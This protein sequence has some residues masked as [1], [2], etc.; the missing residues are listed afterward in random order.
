M[1]EQDFEVVVVWWRGGGRMVV[2]RERMKLVDVVECE[3]MMVH[4]T[5]V[6]DS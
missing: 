1:V 2:M 4:G 6:D 5:I 3:R